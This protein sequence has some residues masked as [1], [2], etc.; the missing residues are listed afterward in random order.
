M[1]FELEVRAHARGPCQ[2]SNAY[3][4]IV[5]LGRS[6]WADARPAWTGRVWPIRTT[7]AASDAAER[8]ASDPVAR[9]AYQGTRGRYTHRCWRQPSERRQRYE[10]ARRQLMRDRAGSAWISDALVR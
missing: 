8:D 3:G 6:R 5:Y 1:L 10:Q 2:S 9:S 7:A 4:M